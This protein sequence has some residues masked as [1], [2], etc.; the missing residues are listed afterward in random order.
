MMHSMERQPRFRNPLLPLPWLA[1]LTLSCG[2]PTGVDGSAGTA[3]ATVSVD[4]LASTVVL[5]GDV[6]LRAAV[7]DVDG[8]VVPDA[9]VVWTVRDA[10]IASVSP[11]GVVT[12]RAVGSTQV[13]ASAGG[14]SAVASITVQL[15]PVA[16]VSVQPAAPSL[17]VGASL[18]LSAGLA[19]AAGTTLTNRTVTWISSDASVA[20]VTD[21]GLVTALAPGTTT[22]A[23]TSEGKTGIARVTVTLVPLATVTVQP[24]TVSLATGGTTTLTAIMTD[25]NGAPATRPVTWTSSDVRVAGV[26]ATGIVTAATPGTAT[27]TAASEGKT[28]TATVTVTAVPTASVTVEPATV[29]VQT[30]R[31]ATLTATVKDANGNVLTGRAVSWT[32]SNLLVAT[33]TESGGVVTGLLPGT[34]TISATADGK[35]GSATVT[36]TLVPVASVAVQPKTASLVVGRTTTLGAVVTDANGAQTDRPVTW[37][38]TDDAVATVSAPGLVTARSAGSARIIASSE[39]KADT[40]VVSVTGPAGP[41]PVASVTVQPPLLGLRVGETRTVT[42]VLKDAN[43]NLLTGRVVTWVSNNPSVR[44]VDNRDGTAVVTALS[45]GGPVFVTASSE[46]WNGST[47]ITITPVPVGTVTLPPSATLVAGQSTT[48]TP[49]VLDSTGAPTTGRFVTWK[50]SNE[51]VATVSW[52]GDGS[53]GVVKALA[54]GQATITATS[55]GKSDNTVVTVTPAPVASVSVLPSAPTLISGATVSLTATVKDANGTTVTNRVV[56]WKSTNEAIA[57]VSSTGNVTGLKAGTAMVIATSESKA[58]TATVT[59]VPGP[60]ATVSVAPAAVTIRDGTSVQLTAT[61]QDAHGNVITGRPFTWISSDGSRVTL[62]STGPTT[63]RVTA[64]KTGTVIVTATL[65][66]ASDTSQITVTP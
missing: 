42:A 41:A 44:V 49:T 11:S 52:T 12:G 17:V 6:P 8:N 37:K 13:A 48:L 46:G 36:V 59:V 3:V 50:S 21:A 39:S 56:T 65:D 61:A 5:G 28:G 62:L 53:P 45:V 22:I 30:L 54:P 27:I 34:A 35:S 33:V 20:T 1:L 58:D 66:G 60:A 26:S 16:T 64:K 15:P 51:A 47:S 32:S 29:T 55:E 43:G 19:D 57:L 31:T 40:A 38:S 18:T 2:S 23:A 63:V 4:P 14:R 24:S 10:G 9:T 25:V 7:I